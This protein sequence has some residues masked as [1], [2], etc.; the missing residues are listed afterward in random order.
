[1]PDGTLTTLRRWTKNNRL[2]GEGSYVARLRPKVYY[3][4]NSGTHAETEPPPEPPS[5]SRYWLVARELVC[6]YR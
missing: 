4:E 1:M 3:L 6:R 2:D 5:A